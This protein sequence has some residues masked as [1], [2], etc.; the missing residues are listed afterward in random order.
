MEE[1]LSEIEFLALS[2]NRVT[3]L[4]SLAEGRRSRSELAET[5]GASQATLGRILGD[6]EDRE[7]VRRTEGAYAAT[8][9]GRLVAEGFRALLD[10]MAAER[11]L[12]DVV[13]YLPTESMDFDLRHLA[14]ATIVTP[15]ETRPN[16]P[17]QRLLGLMREAASVTAF[18]HALNDQSLSVV[19][20]RLGDQEFEAVLTRGA[21]DSLVADD[22]LRER[23]RRVVSAPSA[24]VRVAEDDIPVAVTIAD[25][26]V[27]ILVRDDRGVVQ[28][29][30][31]TTDDAVREW[32]ERRYEH[33]RVHSEPLT[34]DALEP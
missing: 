24:G 9:T 15:S 33:Y 19:A 28:A 1:T 30:V 8:A 3:V 11:E 29:S 18:S 5:T 31:D 13:A 34:P 12:R 14:E 20:D 2:P 4:E 23:L 7:W 27:N 25:D 6:F 21:V 26:V 10:V 16:A 32:A 17:L 22:T